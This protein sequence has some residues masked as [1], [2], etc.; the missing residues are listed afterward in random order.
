ME[1]RKKLVI[2]LGSAIVTNSKG[3]IDL[4]VLKK[5]AAELK[6][7]SAT[8]NLVLVSSGAVASGKKFITNYKGT[9]LQRKAAAA[10]G[11]PLLIQKYHR[12]FSQHGI[13]VAQALC[14][15]G[16]FANREQF[17]QLKETFHTF[18]KN[19]ILPIVNENDLVSN[20]E[21]KFSD[22]DELATLIAIGFDAD[23]LMIATS[24]GGF[25]DENKK[26]IPRITT[27][28]DT[29]YKM[30]DT[31]KSALGLGG[32][33]SKLTFTRL[34]TSL[35]IQVHICGLAGESPLIQALQG[36]AGTIFTPRKTTLKT[37][38]KWIASGSLTLGTLLLDAGA[39][40]ALKNR[41]S[42]LT[43]GIKKITGHFLAGEVVQLIDEEGTVLGVARTKLNVENM[44][45][46]LRQKNTLAAHAN[47]IVLL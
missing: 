15:R 31:G 39:V 6:N 16:H 43:I 9:L 45:C 25:L 38:L 30:V 12:Y 24:V 44:E 20:L 11:N 41:K 5:I 23:A 46:A 28:N 42:L 13:P 40:K 18:W 22:N 37:R 17:L 4:T 34:A 19:G 33:E 32:M 8:Y 35:G 47:D 36:A 1:K 2:K 26:I 27:I 3:D 7:L 10:I 29:I 14:E 21:I